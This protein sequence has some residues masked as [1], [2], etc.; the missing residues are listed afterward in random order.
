MHVLAL[1]FLRM[2]VFVLLLVKKKEK[3]NL[4]KTVVKMNA[5]AISDDEAEVFCRFTTQKK[6]AKK[7]TPHHQ[8]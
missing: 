3:R 1:E 6:G 5:H 7:N 4:L 8:I 2:S